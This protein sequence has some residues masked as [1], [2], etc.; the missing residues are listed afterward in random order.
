MRSSFGTYK[1]LAC[2]TDPL[3]MVM[4]VDYR[5]L[6]RKRGLREVKERGERGRRSEIG[7]RWREAAWNEGERDEVR[8][9]YRERGR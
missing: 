5:L 4:L 6:M 2:T 9:G 8:G 3:V 1:Q 7:E